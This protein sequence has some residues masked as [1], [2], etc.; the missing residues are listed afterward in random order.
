M[1]GVLCGLES[2]AAIARRIPGA[3]V[4]CAGA[5]PEKAR[6]MARDM[7][8]QGAKR[9]VSFGVAGGLQPG[10]PLGALVIGTRV[11]APGGTWSCDESW[12]TELAGKLP[13]AQ[14]G[15]VWGSEVLV[16]G[17]K[18]KQALHRD[19]DCLIVDMESQCA[20]EIAA[21]TGVPLAVLR[22]VC[23]VAELDVPPIVMKV[24]AEDGRVDVLRALGEVLKN[25][26]Q[27][28][29]LLHVGHGTGRALKTLRQSLHVF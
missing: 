23:D 3:L 20:A 5:R 13:Q 19:R 14:R 18:D 24:I 6:A 8:R 11:V 7:V 10:L 26:L 29:T 21:E 28:S 25:P 12:G 9:L 17:A 2:E 15:G 16:A 1:L 22:A 27:I 4:A